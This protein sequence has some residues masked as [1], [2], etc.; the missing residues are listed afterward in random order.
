MQFTLEHTDAQSKAR[1]GKMSTDHGVIETPIFMPV[2]T[3]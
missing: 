2:G 1:A 3:V